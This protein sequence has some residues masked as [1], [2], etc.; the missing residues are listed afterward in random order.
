MKVWEDPSSFR[1]VLHIIAF[2][3]GLITD[4]KRNEMDEGMWM[5]VMLQTPP[6]DCAPSTCC[7]ANLFFLQQSRRRETSPN[8]TPHAYNLLKNTATL[9]LTLTASSR[10]V[11]YS[12]SHPQSLY[13]CLP[14]PHHYRHPNFDFKV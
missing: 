5:W 9:S 7:T 13:Q 10:N 4:Q 6:E 14:Y 8:Q 2:G 12:T 1:L 3:L 11:Q